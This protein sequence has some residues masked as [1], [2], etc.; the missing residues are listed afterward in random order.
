MKKFLFL[1][2]YHFRYLFPQHRK[3]GL[4]EAQQALVILIIS[5]LP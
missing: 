5:I 2:Y 3:H 1:S 4:L